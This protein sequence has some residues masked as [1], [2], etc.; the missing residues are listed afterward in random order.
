MKRHVLMAS[1]ADSGG[2]GLAC[3]RL[4]MALIRH[5]KSVKSDWLVQDQTMNTP[6]VHQ[7]RYTRLIDKVYSQA[8]SRLAARASALAGLVCKS[9]A[10]IAWPN[11]GFPKYV[12]KNYP[13][14]D[15]IHL[16]SIGSSVLSLNEL[17]LIRCPI[18]WTLHD[19]WP[20]HGLTHYS[21]LDL[22][23][24]DSEHSFRASVPSNRPLPISLRVPRFVQDRISNVLRANIEKKLQNINLFIAPSEWLASQVRANIRSFI[25][26]CIVIPNPI[27]FSF[28]SPIYKA[29]ARH[30][31]GMCQDAFYILYVG[32]HLSDPRKGH[33][34]FKEASFIVHNILS[35]VGRSRPV[36]LAII[37]PNYSINP[38]DYGLDVDQL[39]AAKD[40]YSMLMAYSACDLVCIPSLADNLPN[41]ATEAQACG[42]PV[43]CFHTGGLPEIVQNDMTGIVCNRT[44][45]CDLGHA[46][47]RL[48]RDESV[49]RTMAEASR[50][51]AKKKW[52]EEQV[53]YKYESVLANLLQAHSSDC[54]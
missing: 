25:P 37:G 1:E 52:N 27:D 17:P 33:S 45:S 19:E 44:S 41:V 54:S 39:G 9:Q 47:I 42:C 16:H 4:H 50:E 5:S 20:T 24:S 2:A 26:P 35:E 34:L 14:T 12:A 40:E 8:Q 18:I 28:W 46:L 22:V 36:R 29:K 11:T 7:R 32:T 15:V 53:V 48:I 13:Q 21:R 10:T 38:N 51:L 3:K 43:V 31:L 6:N 30:E 23:H 49:L